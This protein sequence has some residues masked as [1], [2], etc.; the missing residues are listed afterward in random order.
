MF[1]QSL[2]LSACCALLTLLLGYLL[3]PYYV[4]PWDPIRPRWP[5]ESNICTGICRLSALQ[6]AVVSMGS[7][8]RGTGI[9]QP[10]MVVQ[11]AD[12]DTERGAGAGI[13]SRLGHRPPDGGR[14]RGSCELDIAGRR[15]RSCSGLYFFRLEKYVG[16]DA[17]LWRPQFATW[18]G[19]CASDLPAGGEFVLMFVFIGGDYW[20][21]RRFGADAQAAFG[22]G[23]RIM[24]SMFLPAMAV[25][26][27]AAPI[28]GQN[29]AAGKYRAGARN[30]CAWRY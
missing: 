18:R 2:V 15:R 27:A 4:A 25:A 12:G 3:D 29:I 22:I 26:F 10:T 7:A 30:L 16:F 28:V 13:D 14:R 1:N 5:P 8:L 6:F 23:T 20:I 24:Q 17:Q 19:C 11:S 9:V 21:I